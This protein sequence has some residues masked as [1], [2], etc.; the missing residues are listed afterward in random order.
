MHVRPY[1]QRQAGGPAIALTSAWVAW[2]ALF[3]HPPP[4]RRTPALH[5][6]LLWFAGARLAGSLL[7]EACN[8]LIPTYNVKPNIPRQAKPT[9]S[10]STIPRKKLMPGARGRT[11][12]PREV[13]VP[14]K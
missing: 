2:R 9:M 11:P 3:L 10:S 8:G 7:A 5:E 12:E 1:L 14:K 4:P 13:F 6:A